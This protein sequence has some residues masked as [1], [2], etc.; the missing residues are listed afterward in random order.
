MNKEI[1]KK[2]LNL[3]F[4]QLIVDIEKFGIKDVEK[5]KII[6]NI[7]ILNDLKENHRIC[8]MSEFDI[9]KSM[10]LTGL[11]IAYFLS[12][13]FERSIKNFK[14]NKLYM[15]DYVNIALTYVKYYSDNKDF[16]DMDII[17]YDNEEED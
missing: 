17:P 8:K 15:E 1:N 9:I 16:N 14:K 2:S 10:T 11:L 3:T 4:E 7:Q 6:K 12:N 5:T 13:Q